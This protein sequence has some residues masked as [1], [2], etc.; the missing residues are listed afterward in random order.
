MAK[1]PNSIVG[2]FSLAG[3]H[4]RDHNWPAAE[5]E[6]RKTLELREGFAEA[7][8]RLGG[9]LLVQGNRDE[10]RQHLQRALELDPS[11][12]EARENLALLR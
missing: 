4:V 5:T 3:C 7:Q 8:A 10:A 2:H 1:Q 11:L 6:L 12:S 9:V